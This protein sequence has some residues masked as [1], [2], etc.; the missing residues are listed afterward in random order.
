MKKNTVIDL[1]SGAGGLSLGAARAGFTLAGAVELDKNAIATHQ[2]NF[3]KVTHLAE[4]I[5]CLSGNALLEKCNL[6]AG[7]LTGLIGGPPCQ[8]FSAIGP[9]DP[10]DSR[11]ELFGHFMRLVAETQPVFF[12]AENV[13]GIMLEKNRSTVDRALTHVEKDYV[14]LT[15]FEA[16]ANLLG[17]P[18]IRTRLFFIGIR[19]DKASGIDSDIFKDMPAFEN[20]NV[21]AALKGLPEEI[22]AEWKGKSTWGEA[23]ALPKGYFN[24][25]VQSEI[26]NGLGDPETLKLYIEKRSV[27]GCVGTIHSPELTKRYG[28]LLPGSRDPISRS[29]RLEPEGYCPTLRAGTGPDKGSY[30]AVRPI[31]PSQPRVITPREAARLQGFPDWFWLPEAK[32]HAFRQIGNSVS[33]LVAEAVLNQVA[34]SLGFLQPNP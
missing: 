23:Q 18:T 33:P 19:K 1:F 28:D 32:W 30:Q 7:E 10:K 20:V 4:D 17:A 8:G 13:P 22:S 29:S 25:R 21:T 31:H 27:S 15:P 24:D 9:K 6:A 3:P 5:A 12:A 2:K 26:P 34:K 16:K 11:N 14:L